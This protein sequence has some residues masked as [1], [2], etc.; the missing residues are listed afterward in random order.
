MAETKT[1][2]TKR[3]EFNFT[4]WNSWFNS[5]LVRTNPLSRNDDTNYKLFH[6]IKKSKYKTNENWHTVINN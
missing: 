4:T 6:I 5:L 3:V 1:K 2:K